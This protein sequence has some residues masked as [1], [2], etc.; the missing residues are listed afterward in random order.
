M[1][2]KTVVGYLYQ[3]AEAHPDKTAVIANG[4]TA[5]YRQ[6]ADLV[7]RYAAF[8][9]NNGL[10]KSDIIVV[11]SSQSL[12]FVVAY[13][14]AH[15]AGCVIAP[16]EKSIPEAGILAIAEAIGAK[17]VISTGDKELSCGNF[18]Y[19]DSASILLDAQNTE[20][21]A[22]SLPDPEDSADILFTTGTTGSSKGVEIS[23]KALIATA[24]R[25]IYGC[26][27]KDDTVLIIPGP[28]NHAGSLRKLPATI[29]NGSTIHILNGM[30]NLKAFYDALDNAEG[31]LSCFLSPAMIRT[32]F[33]LSED[34]I[35]RYAGKF[36]SIESGG[37]SPPELDKQRLC[38]LFPK[39]RLYNIYGSSESAYICMYDYN[40]NPGKIGC[41][42]KVMPHSQIIIVDD[43]RKVIQ[44]STDHMGYLAIMSDTNMKGYINDPE[45]TR[46]VLTDGIVYTNDVGYIDAEG[47]V[48]L[49]GRKGDVIN[50][51]GLKVAPA[52][53][54]AAA[55][56][57][58][59]IEDCICVPVRH[60]ISGYAPKLLVVMRDDVVFSGQEISN[61]LRKKLEGYKVPIK[62]EK[63]DSIAKT[64]N[65]KLDRKAYLF[66]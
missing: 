18:I 42:G 12:D 36:D 50:V 49:V 2:G 52:E 28:L 33:T 46:Q 35:G 38:Q 27:Y 53:V 30:T 6:L 29:V 47:F 13:F 15:T 20:P 34:V 26:Q 23:Y 63:V 24:E 1:T 32:L 4:I 22:F 45:Q 14:A 66:E 10:Q 51:G 61:E 64:Y 21:M 11:R 55:L 44:S 43:D 19:F 16:A 59:G 56:S 8:L 54:E 62:Y 60:P 48:Y 31:F 58:E 9:R 5:S 25:A 39:T 57:I 3:H 41:V 17:A 65:G 37:A 40:A 7:R